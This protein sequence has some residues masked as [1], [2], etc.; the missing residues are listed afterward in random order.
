MQ[1]SLEQLSEL[2]SL[3]VDRLKELRVLGCNLFER[4]AKRLVARKSFAQFTI[5]PAS[6][7]GILF[8][9]SSDVR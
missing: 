2:P 6:L 5:D 9:V 4:R 7:R 1:V 8:H 3:A